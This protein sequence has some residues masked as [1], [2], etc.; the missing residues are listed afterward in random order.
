MIGTSGDRVIGKPKAHHRAREK[1]NLPT[2]KTLPLMN[3]DD[4]GS[5]PLYH[6]ETA[7]TEEER[8][9]KPLPM[10]HGKPVQV[11]EM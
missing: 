6:R 5:E 8:K 7:G 11:N 2:E 10:I 4:R 1:Q 9:T 3:A